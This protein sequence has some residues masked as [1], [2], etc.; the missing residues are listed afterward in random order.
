MLF[1]GGSTVQDCDSEHWSS[2]IV[3][4][5]YLQGTTRWVGLN[6]PNIFCDRCSMV[7]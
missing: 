4:V 7:T 5:N 3:I 6:E 1:S 2:E